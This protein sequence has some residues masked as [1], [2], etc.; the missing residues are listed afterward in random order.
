MVEFKLAES[1]LV[2]QDSCKIMVRGAEVKA[3]YRLHK[4]DVR[5]PLDPTGNPLTMWCLHLPQINATYVD[6]T[7]ELV[8]EAFEEFFEQDLIRHLAHQLLEEREKR[9]NNKWMCLRLPVDPD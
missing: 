8:F 2:R 7:E 6:E 3:E 1:N 5:N 4:D 9:A